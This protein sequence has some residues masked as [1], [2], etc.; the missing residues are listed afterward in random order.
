[1][2]DS[3]LDPLAELRQHAYGYCGDGATPECF[4]RMRDLLETVTETVSR[5]GEK[6]DTCHC[7]PGAYDCALHEALSL[8]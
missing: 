7:V 4:G 5:I 3:E 1:M 2:A 8:L 6:I